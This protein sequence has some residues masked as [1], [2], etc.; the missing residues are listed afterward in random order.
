M[1]NVKVQT[2]IPLTIVDNGQRFSP[3]KGEILE[4]P[5]ETAEALI[6]DAVAE[7][8]KLIEPSGKITITENRNGINVSQYAE[9]D[10]NV[11]EPTGTIVITQNGEYNVKTNATAE[12][13]VAVTPRLVAISTTGLSGFTN[14]D[15]KAVAQTN[16]CLSINMMGTMGGQPFNYTD[17]YCRPWSEWDAGSGK[18][19]ISLGLATPDE[20]GMLAILFE[21]DEISD[22]ENPSYIARVEYASVLMGGSWIDIS[23]MV[24]IT[25]MGIFKVEGL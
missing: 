9:A 2:T 24:T 13:N 20:A 25:G 22:P 6:A 12:V 8:Y 4:V 23:N 5:E 18:S 7:E 10:V 11:P 15:I 21:Y 1:A 3:R 16:G 17:A 14:E 19:Y